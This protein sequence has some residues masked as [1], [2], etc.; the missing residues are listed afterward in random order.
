MKENTNVPSAN[1]DMNDIKNL[2]SKMQYDIN[3]RFD[4]VDQRFDKIDQRLD[5]VDQRFDKVDKS[6]DILARQVA[7]NMQKI[8]TL[9]IKEDSDLKYTKLMKRLD[10]AMERMNYF[11]S[12]KSSVDFIIGRFDR[13]IEEHTERLEKVESAA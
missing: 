7:A 12:W 10:D 13:K 8:D 4:K 3:E 1:S 2:L 11:S 5:K 9:E 6:L